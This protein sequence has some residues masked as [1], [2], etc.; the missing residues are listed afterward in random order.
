MATDG[1]SFGQKSAPAAK[2]D[3]QEWNDVQIVMP[4]SK[5]T[6]FLLVGTLRLGSDISRFVDERAG[7]GLSL[8]LGKYVTLAPSYLYIGMQPSAGRKRYEN[9]LT[10]AATFGLPLEKFTISDRNQFERRIRHPQVDAIRYRNRLQIEHPVSVAS[11]KM[12]V[13]VSDEIFY[14]WSLHGWV[15]NR[16]AIGVSRRFSRHFTEDFYY[17]R[18]SDGVTR[19]GDLNVIGTIFRVRL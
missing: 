13:F 6:D 10:L 15:R 17:L 19:P 1:S 14:D 18:Q 11:F 16:F 3:T 12:Q 5:T 7:I 9:R 8:R 4:I 2:A